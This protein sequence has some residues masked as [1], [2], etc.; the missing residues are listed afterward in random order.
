MGFKKMAYKKSINV[1]NDESNISYY[2]WLI[3]A[4]SFLTLSAHGSARMSF[5][6]FQVALIDEF[7]WSRGALGGAFSLMMVFYALIGPFI[8][9]FFERNFCC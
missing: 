5:S 1:K 3:V 6:L 7:G 8:G 9:S 2:G 4:L